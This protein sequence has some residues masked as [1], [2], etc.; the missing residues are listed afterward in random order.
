MEGICILNFLGVLLEFQVFWLFLYANQNSMNTDHYCSQKNL[1]GAINIEE[2]VP[3]NIDY[4]HSI[5]HDLFLAR[6]KRNYA[7]NRM[8]HASVHYFPFNTLLRPTLS[9]NIL[10]HSFATVLYNFLYYIDFCWGISE[11]L[12]LFLILCEYE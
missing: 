7:F 5:M 9:A 4:S 1:W 8:L 10:L 6:N 2:L 12:H 3:N 11:F